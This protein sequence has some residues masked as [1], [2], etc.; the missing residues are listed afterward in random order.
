M[1]VSSSRRPCPGENLGGGVSIVGR[2]WG[3][4][5]LL[6][7]PEANQVDSEWFLLLLEY[8]VP[9]PFTVGR[10]DPLDGNED[11]DCPCPKRRTPSLSEV[12]ANPGENL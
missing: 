1:P 10:K 6:G 9:C 7:S 2:C 5:A 11:I 4:Q 3:W 8:Y 12:G